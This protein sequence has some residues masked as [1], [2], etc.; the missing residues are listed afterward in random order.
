MRPRAL[1]CID[2]INKGNQS[3]S[4]DVTW[5]R[6]DATAEGVPFRASFLKMYLW[7]GLFTLC[8]LACQV[9]VS[10]G[11]A[12]LSCCVLVFYVTSVKHLLPFVCWLCFGFTSRPFQFYHVTVSALP[13]NCQFYHVTVSVLPCD[14]VNF[15]YATVS[16]LPRDCI[17][18][19]MWLFQ[20]YHETLFQI[21]PSTVSVLPR[22]CFNFTSKPCF[23]LPCD[24]V[25]IYHAANSVLPCGHVSIYHAAVS[26]LPCDHVSI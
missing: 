23:S 2:L 10:V 11:D 26:V 15:T 3:C 22:D 21:Y 9:R 19:T 5:I 14:C 20:F 13:R 1:N 25:S 12:G 8:S 6:R 16:V 4:T 24:H 18:F 7:R 17:S